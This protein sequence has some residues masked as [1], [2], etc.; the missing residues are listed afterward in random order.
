MASYRVSESSSVMLSTCISTIILNPRSSRGIGLE[1]VKQ[2]TTDRS[3]T[4]FATCRC[5]DSSSA[6]QSLKNASGNLH[7]V[8]LDVRDEGSISTAVCIVQAI[9]GARGLDYLINNAGQI[10]SHC[11]VF[12]GLCLEG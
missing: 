1:F 4:V 6:L 9:L 3:N 5:P 12:S 7:I 2:L 11:C 8:Q 10:V